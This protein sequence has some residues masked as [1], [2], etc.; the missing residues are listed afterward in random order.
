MRGELMALFETIPYLKIKK[1]G[2]M[3]LR[4]YDKVMLASSISSMTPSQDAG[5]SDVF[6]YISGEN[7]QKTKISMTTPVVTYEENKQLI[8]GFFIPKKY[9]ETTIP[10]PTSKDVFINELKK[11]Y[12]IVIKFNGRWTHKNFE[13]HNMMLL[14]YMK[15]KGYK[16]NSQKIIL[17]YQPPFIPSFLRRNEI[18]YHIEDPNN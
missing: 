4:Q 2:R 14:D 17:R 3:E 11:S 10:Q 8:T 12:Y 16:A 5:F 15:Q 18:A 1:E 7:D 13:K 9:T 6:R